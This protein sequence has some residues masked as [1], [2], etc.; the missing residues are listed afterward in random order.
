MRRFLRRHKRLLLTA[1]GCALLAWLVARLGPAT[2][3]SALDE[4]GAR[5]AWLLAIYLAGT[6]AVALPWRWLL[7]REARPGWMALLTSRLAASGVNAVDPVFGVSGEPCRLLWL[8]SGTLLAGTAGLLADRL[9]YWLATAIFLLACSAIVLSSGVVPRVHALVGFG[10]AAGWVA[11]SVA[12]R[13]LAVGRGLVGPLARLIRRILRR[14]AREA[15]AGQLEVDARLREL[16]SRPGPL[17]AGVALHLAGRIL[18]AAETWIAL[19]ALDAS[20]DFPRTVYVCAV[21]SI[22]A[23]IGA[24]VPGQLGV[25]EGGMVLAFAAA[26]LDPRLGLAVVTLQRVRQLFS[27]A[28]GG[29]VLAAR[30]GVAHGLPGKGG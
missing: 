24:P 26:G 7:P 2:I 20:L 9:L 13:Q 30:R 8:G 18:L 3:V 22:I 14:P 15:S 4:A 5:I 27:V 29:A 19:L 28:L 25:Q 1:L 23:L 17:V 12:F 21:P 6:A 16:L 10:L 11:A